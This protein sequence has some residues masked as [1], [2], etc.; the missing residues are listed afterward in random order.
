MESET[1]N[2][3]NCK[4]DFIIEP[5]DFNFYEKLKV[6]APTWC[7][8][9]R[10]I[11]RVIFRNERFL[12]KKTDFKTGKE[13]FSAYPRDSVLK[14]YD[15][16]F[17]W[18]D[19]WDAMEYGR[20]Y[21]FS[22]SFFEQFN[23]LRISVPSC[24]RLI[25]NSVNSDYCNNVLDFKNCYMTFSG[26]IGENLFYG[27]GANSLKD[28]MDFY[29]TKDSISCY[30]TFS[31]IDSYEVFFSI[32]CGGC[33]NV[34]FSLNC[35]DCSDCFGCVNLN[36]KKYCIFNEQYT[37]EEY[38]DRISEFNLGS[39]SFLLD[40]KEKV[41]EFRKKFPIKFMHTMQSPNCSGDYIYGS[42]NIKK[43][44]HIFKSENL[45]FSQSLYKAKD[46]YDYTISG[47]NSELIYEC[48][49]CGKNCSNLK[50]CLECWP[51]SNNLEYC[52]EC[53]SCSDCFGCVGLKKKQYSIFNKQYSKEEY[54]TLREKIIK[55]MYHMPYIDE[56]N[57]IYKYGEFFPLEFS[58]FA[59]NE[60]LAL[61][62]FPTSKEEVLNQ[63]Y[64]W[65]DPFK[66]DYKIEIMLNEL[67]D[68]I[69]NI[70]EEI[71]NKTI[72]CAHDG[73]CECNCSSAFKIIEGEF[74]FYK[75]FNLPIPRLCPNCRFSERIK[76]LNPIN[77][78]HQKCNCNG[79]ISSNKIY[80]NTTKHFHDIQSCPNE[81]ETSYS[82]DRQE[83]IY[84]EKCYQQEVY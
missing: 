70:N 39:Y 15:H 19:N 33:R 14:I 13:I 64:I 23:E 31:V 20:S 79:I 4:K 37:K 30:E 29:Y 46:S 44:F 16:N 60:T 54:I 1:R 48:T 66:R 78:Y 41:K 24:S 59:Y 82:P 5:E 73:L 55:H 12:F 25:E 10:A 9:C 47:W 58:S 3:Q 7:S 34:W 84:C 32:E 53:H 38:R 72:A 40:I 56:E 83:I 50:F 28:S 45:K 76:Q 81:F 8:R 49:S 67:P 18:S 51:N 52:I 57:R 65:R 77:F 80:K 35:R 62:Y 61:E 2:C 21:D 75:K 71:I 26:G 36:H 11:R 17:W 74:Q 6:P 42:K 22:R 27:V 69:K 43:S 68:D 63:G